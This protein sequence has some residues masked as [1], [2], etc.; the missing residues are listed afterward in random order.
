MAHLAAA[1]TE[2]MVFS[3]KSAGQTRPVE[4][5]DALHV[6]S[7]L[8][9]G[10]RCPKLIPKNVHVCVT[11]QTDLAHA[12]LHRRFDH[13][14]PTSDFAIRMHMHQRKAAYLPFF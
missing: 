1:D 8:V 2:A 13:Y 7:M 6:L 3:V 5:I 10:L 12:G 14:V 9:T 11:G 4:S